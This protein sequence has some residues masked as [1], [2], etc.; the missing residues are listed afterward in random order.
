MH[1]NFDIVISI[2]V[3][4]MFFCDVIVVMNDIF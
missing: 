1:Y 2:S 4:T 3:L